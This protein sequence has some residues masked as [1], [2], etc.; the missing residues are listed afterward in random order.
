MRNQS[1][2]VYHS[3]QIC[4]MANNHKILQFRIKQLSF[5]QFIVLKD[6]SKFIHKLYWHLTTEEIYVYYTSPH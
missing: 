5:I 1:I 2:M 6:Q 3:D 4:G